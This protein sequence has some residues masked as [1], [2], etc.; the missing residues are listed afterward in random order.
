MNLH[1]VY[2]PAIVGVIVLSVAGAIAWGEKVK[3]E[4]RREA[5]IASQQ[6]E[7]TKLQSKITEDQQQLKEEIAA[8][9]QQ[10]AT[11][12]REPS[13]APEI[14]SSLLR[15]LN[16]KAAPV[17]QTAPITKE[18]LPDAPTAV[19]TKQNQL[20]FAEAALSCKQCFLE[21]QHYQ[22]QLS[23]QQQIID[24]NKVELSAALKAAKGG[25]F[26]QRTGRVA[27]WGAIFGAIGYTIGRSQK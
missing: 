1:K 14:I 16:P 4:A 5:V 18:T 7:I 10:K 9:Q 12:I 26:W 21:N 8:V 20:D 19:L 11:V 27:K 25:S 24:R 17:Q 22:V 2:I 6:T 23:D 15:Q 13:Q 3:D